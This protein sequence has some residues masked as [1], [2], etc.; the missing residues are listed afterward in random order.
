[1]NTENKDNLAFYHISGNKNG[2]TLLFL[3]GFLGS[4]EEWSD[5]ADYLRASCQI[6]A[7]DLPGHGKSLFEDPLS[8]QMETCAAIII[9][10][11]RS[12]K[13]ENVYLVGYSMGGRLALHL[14]IHHHEFFKQILL[15]STSPGIKEEQEKVTRIK[16][17]SILAR[18]LEQEDF[19]LFLERWYDAGLFSSLK[20][21]P[22]LL[23][24]IMCNR[25]D[26][27]PKHLARSLDH[28]GV[29][30]QKPLWQQLSE[31]KIPLD[32]VVGTLDTKFVSIG[33]EMQSCNPSTINLHLIENA[34]HVVHLE[35]KPAFYTLVKEWLTC[36]Q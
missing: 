29:G 35:N 8:Y 9:N 21:Q 25:K 2:P 11:L 16:N 3:H 13:L 34:G 5:I 14:A 18:S 15:I 12:L 6:L 32:V 7:V 22:E 36:E 30:R 26:N 28:M 33:K 1:M 24:Q 31:I 23:N 4:K 10:L 20:I 27:S 19:N 17:D